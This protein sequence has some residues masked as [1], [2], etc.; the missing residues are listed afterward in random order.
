MSHNTTRQSTM[1]K[2]PGI[3]IC[4]KNLSVRYYSAAS[5]AGGGNLVF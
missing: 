5:F 2:K 4:R 3:L 1:P